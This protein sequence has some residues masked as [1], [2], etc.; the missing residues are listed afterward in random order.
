MKKTISINKDAKYALFFDLDGT[1]LGSDG[2]IDSEARAQIQRVKS[3]GNLIFINT[4][5]SKAHLPRGLA[6]DP[7]FDGIICGAAYIE[8]E[9]TVLME[10]NLSPLA[11]KQILS[12]AKE[13]SV[14]VIFEGVTDDYYYLFPESTKGLSIDRD[15]SFEDFLRDEVRITKMTF[16]RVISDFDTESITEL[17]VIK[18]KTYAEG[19]ILG[20]DKARAMNLLLEHLQIPRERTI[21]FGDSENDIEMLNNSGLSVAMPHGASKAKEASDLVLTIDEALKRIFPPK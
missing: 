3:L 10:K 19:I 18:F 5:R 15:I 12:F 1:L 6:K 20:C 2:S 8:L 11:K 21:S 17:R 4:G 7:L 14:P 13:H 9:G 16:C